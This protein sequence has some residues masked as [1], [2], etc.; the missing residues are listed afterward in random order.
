MASGVDMDEL[1]VAAS[2][3]RADLER[4]RRSTESRG[5]V[6]ELINPLNDDQSLMRQ[7]IVSGLVRS[8][9]YNQSRSEKNMQLCEEEA[10]FLADSRGFPSLVRLLP[11]IPPRKNWRDHWFLRTGEGGECSPRGLML[12]TDYASHPSRIVLNYF[13]ATMRPTT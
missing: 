10:V 7:S 9:A 2:T 8:V 4:L 6:V 5:E 3:L 1:A 11:M 12:L 13:S